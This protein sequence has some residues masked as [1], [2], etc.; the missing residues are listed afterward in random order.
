MLP[1]HKI[2]EL[3]RIFDKNGDGLVSVDELLWILEK[4][5]VHVIRDELEL[6]VGK[7]ALNS[8]DFLFFYET[9]MIKGCEL[10]LRDDDDE[11]LKRAF[12]VFDLDG[13]GLISCEELQIALSRLGLYCGQDCKDMIGMYDTNL[14]GYVD[15][16][17]FKDMMLNDLSI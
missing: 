11:V 16:E 15:F 9:L 6:F 1:P 5:D 14:D 12:K 17:E 7:Q 3:H 2:Q 13:D 10:E 4:I 8:I